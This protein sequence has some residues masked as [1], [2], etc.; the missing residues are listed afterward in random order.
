MGSALSTLPIAT[1][2]TDTVPSVARAMSSAPPVAFHR[3][4]MWM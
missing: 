3:T 4:T 1:R 2:N